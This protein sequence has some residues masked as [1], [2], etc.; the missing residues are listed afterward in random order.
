VILPTFNRPD[1]LGRALDCL[2]A[3]TFRAFE[4]VVVNDGG[5]GVEAVLQRFSPALSITYVRHGGNRGPAAARNSGLA[6]ARGTY[7]AYLDDDDCYRPDHLDALVTA[8]RRGSH[9]VAYADASWM[10]EE[11]TAAGYGP[12]RSILE[13]SLGFDR[14]RLMV[15]SYI[16]ILSVMHERSCL[17]EVGVFDEALGTHEDWD[18]QIRLAA[19]FDFLHLPRVTAEVSWREDGSSAASAQA[20]DFRRTMLTIHRRYHHLVQDK[21][22]VIAGQAGLTGAVSPPARDAATEVVAQARTQISRGDL[23]GAAGT[24]SASMDL[25]RQSAELLLTLADV[26]T[27]QRKPDVADQ[28]LQQAALLHP[29]NQAIRSRLQRLPD[30]PVRPSV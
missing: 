7:V 15:A 2:K 1:F 25:A 21:P 20:P 28:V 27:A 13:R 8:L 3:Q 16:P 9:R 24:L 14:D 19:R 22:H 18:L 11:K 6:I 26:F 17:D 23:E 29:Q 4:V 5:A 12:V 10:L 30:G